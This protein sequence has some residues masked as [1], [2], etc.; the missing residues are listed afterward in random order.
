MMSNMLMLLA[1]YE[2][3]NRYVIDLYRYSGKQNWVLRSVGDPGSAL[4]K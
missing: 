4:K 2:E 3:Q 1:V